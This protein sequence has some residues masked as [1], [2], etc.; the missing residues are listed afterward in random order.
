MIPSG[1]RLNSFIVHLLGTVALDDGAPQSKGLK[2]NFVGEDESFKA[3][4]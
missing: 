3:S 2:F 4:L 1:R